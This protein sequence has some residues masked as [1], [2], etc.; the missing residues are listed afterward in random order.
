[1]KRR[2]AGRMG[3]HWRHSRNS[4]TTGGDGREA[5]RR[6]NYEAGPGHRA[7]G[8]AGAGGGAQAGCSAGWGG[9][10]LIILSIG[11]EATEPT[12]TARPIALIVN[13]VDSQTIVLTGRVKAP[14]RRATHSASRATP[15]I[16]LNR[17]SIRRNRGL[18][19][20]SRSH[21]AIFCGEPLVM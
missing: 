6:V 3:D 1:M 14:I 8:G 18:P 15:Q 7:M 17:H 19:A 12:M 20:E 11:I 4:H 5:K 2:L 16:A 13:T 10:S 21:A 9:S